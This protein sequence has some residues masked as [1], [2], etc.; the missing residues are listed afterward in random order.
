MYD[1]LTI[2]N[3]QGETICSIKGP[4]DGRDNVYYTKVHIVGKYIYAVFS[5]KDQTEEGAFSSSLIDV[6][7]FAGNYIKTL[8]V[9]YQ[10]SDFCYDKENNR[11]VFLFNDTIQFGYMPLTE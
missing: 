2:A 3:L 9:G 10:I 4:N 11:F 6:F 1:M 7:D 8:D 5:G